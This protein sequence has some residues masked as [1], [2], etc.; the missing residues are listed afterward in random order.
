M[1]MKP[2]RKN[3]YTTLKQQDLPLDQNNNYLVKP[4]LKW[5]GGKRQLLKEYSKY[6]PDKIKKYYEPFVGAGAVLF[7]LQHK[8]SII[9]DKNKDLI[10]CY[11]C[12]KNNVE[13]VIFE[14]KQHKNEVDYFYYIRDI[15]RT[16]D[17]LNF[18]DEQK[19]ARIIFLNKTCFNG[20]F[21]VNSQGQFN[22]PFGKYNNP[23]FNN[24]IVLHA[25]NKYLNAT[26]IT[27]LNEDF[28][29]ALENAEKGDFVY[30]DPPYDPISDTS[31][32]TGYNMDKF[33]K[34]DQERLRDCI[35]NLTEK[36]C[37]VMLSNSSTE[38]IKKLYN[39]RCYKI[40]P[41][42]AIRSINSDPTGRGKIEEL[43]I[44][45]YAI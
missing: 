17:F 7:H 40:I 3:Y 1:E 18:T 26:N 37:K 9:S 34:E 8:T 15:E 42:P 38:F 21:R 29:V 27:I 4:F 23:N 33:N 5:A 36:G 24:E 45:N 25:V 43:L 2:Q 19:A 22:V 39:E 6:F 16:A 35:D 30:L 41:I 44:L 32:F 31:S 13:Q 10:N 11:N 20:L 12:I 28:A 14:L